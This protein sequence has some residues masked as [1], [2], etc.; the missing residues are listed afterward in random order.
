MITG[1]T[2]F[3]KLNICG[4][5]NKPN[6]RMRTLYNR[7]QRRI[8]RAA[9]RYRVA[10]EAVYELEPD[11]TW[12][13]QFRKLDPCDI[14]GPGKQRDDLLQVQNGRH[15]QSWIW[16]T[17]HSFGG[18]DTE[19]EFDK[20][21]RAEWAKM[22][23][24]RDRWEEEYRLVVEEMRRTVAY[25]EWKAMWWRGQCHRRQDVDTVMQLGLTAYAERQAWSM[26]VLAQS[27][28]VKWVPTIS[29]EGI[30][31]DWATKYMPEVQSI[32][33]KVVDA[34]PADEPWEDEDGYSDDEKETDKNDGIFDSY[35]FDD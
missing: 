27:C 15:E 19:E 24:R 9:N 11:G 3:K 29:T 6:T 35:D 17:C 26:E 33:S 25:L 1:L 34:E 14:R 18:D 22:R 21:M 32:L 4:A 13:D 31:A 20:I 23:A 28:V 8:Q 12:H 7:L 2:Q 10:R 16:T 30:K 5:G